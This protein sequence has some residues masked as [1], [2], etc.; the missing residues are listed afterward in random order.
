VFLIDASE[1]QWYLTKKYVLPRHCL[2]C[3][4][5]RKRDRESRGARSLQEALS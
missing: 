2:E 3:R 1:V 4:R 5:R